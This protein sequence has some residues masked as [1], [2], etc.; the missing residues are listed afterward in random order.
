MKSIL[1]A[2]ILILSVLSISAEQARYD[3]YRVYNIAVNDDVQLKVLKELSVISDSVSFGKIPHKLDYVTNSFQYN[4][5]SSPT[6]IGTNVE[7]IVPPHQF[8]HFGELVEKFNLQVTL[9][10]SNL[11]E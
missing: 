1:S 9:T 5:W 11:Q 10:N 4:F 6:S 7:L 8:A 2:A 3:N